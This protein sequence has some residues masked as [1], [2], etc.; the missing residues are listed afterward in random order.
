[1]K[2]VSMTIGFIGTGAIATA[3]VTGLS[4][5]GGTR[6]P[7]R[8]SPRNAGTAAGLASRF[9]N[10]SVCASNQEVLDSSHTVVLAVRPQVANAVLSEIR[11]SSGQNVISLIAGFPLRRITDLV[12]PAVNI[13]R[14]IPLP[15][16]VQRRGPIAIHP[17]AGAAAQLFG[18]LGRVFGVEAE[19]HFNAFSTATSTLAAHFGFVGCVASWVAREGPSG[20]ASPGLYGAYV[21]GTSRHK[22]KEIR[23]GLR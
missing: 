7:I 11:F 15:S 18:P 10:V 2:N 13:W 6:P 9:A 16:V 21:R 20:I 23:G 22:L 19:D 5:E 4:S 8:L 17:A 1:M 12:A 3:I 14:A